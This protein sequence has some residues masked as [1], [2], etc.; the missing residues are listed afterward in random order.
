MLN[1]TGEHVHLYHICALIYVLLIGQWLRSEREPG[2][3]N[4]TIDIAQINLLVWWLSIPPKTI[5]K[6]VRNKSN[7]VR[8]PHE[9]QSDEEKQ[10]NKN[11]GE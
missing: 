11:S 6:C 5:A 2:M 8:E 10:K 1:E 3:Q 7:F 4:E 9:Q